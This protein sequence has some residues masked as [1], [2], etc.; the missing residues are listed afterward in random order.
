[1][2]LRAWAQVRVGVFGCVGVR[3]SARGCVCAGECGCMCVC[4]CVRVCGC[5]CWLLGRLRGCLVV[6]D[7]V[8][9]VGVW[10]RGCGCVF[11]NFETFFVL[12]FSLFVFSL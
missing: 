3:G 7:G 12:C 1:M 11:V 4:L 5:A 6:G 10:V 8:V 9:C 2:W